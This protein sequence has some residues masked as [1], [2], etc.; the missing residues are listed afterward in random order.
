MDAAEVKDML[1]VAGH[2]KVGPASVF[3]VALGAWGASWM[4]DALHAGTRTLP[5]EHAVARAALC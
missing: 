5:R 2:V 3:R 1:D 4:S